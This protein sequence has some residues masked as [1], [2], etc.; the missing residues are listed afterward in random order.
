M[1]KMTFDKGVGALRLSSAFSILPS[2]IRSDHRTNASRAPMYTV[3]GQVP[4][5]ADCPEI[6]DAFCFTR[7]Q[8]EQRL[9][10]MQAKTQIVAARGYRTSTGHPVL[11][12]GFL[13]HA[14][15]LL[16]EVRGELDTIPD[17]AKGLRIIFVSPPKTPEDQ[18]AGLFANCEEN[19]ERLDRSPVDTA[20]LIKRAIAMQVTKEDIAKELGCSVRVVDRHL[21]LL[22]LDPM[23][24]L[25]V[26]TGKVKMS[27][28][29]KDASKKGEGTGR[30]KRAGVPHTKLRRAFAAISESDHG[31]ERRASDVTFTA[32][33]ILSALSWGAGVEN[34]APPESIRKFIED[35]PAKPKKKAGRKKK[36]ATNAAPSPAPKKKSKSKKAVAKDV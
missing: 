26:H 3:L 28:V 11:K 24:Q 2:K 18:V 36:A 23:V 20:W 34:D 30:G 35:A 7:A 21:S 22:A 1:A 6:S 19:D 32:E 16:A 10:S 29:L 5:I 33:E 4:E 9:A 15:M 13:R 8:V 25:D 27:A 12:E 31:A 17:G 14:A